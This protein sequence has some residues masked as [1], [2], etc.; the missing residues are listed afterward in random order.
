MNELARTVD[1]HTKLF[2]YNHMEI[3]QLGVCELLVTFKGKSKVC[4]LY[5]VDFLT[6]ILGIHGSDEMG[7][8]SVYLDAFDIDTVVDSV[9]NGEFS[10]KIKHDY[11]D[12]FHGI[13]HME[14]R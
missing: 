11:S 13:W 12:L 9:S 10:I 2:A 8:I 5:F 6:A 4:E 14:G 3:R 7:V 1:K